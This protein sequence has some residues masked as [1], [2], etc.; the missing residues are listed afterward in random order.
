MANQQAEN[1]FRALIRNML[2][3]GQYP[4]HR[5]VRNALGTRNSGSQL[6]SGLTQEQTRWRAEEVERAGYDWIAS[7]AASRLVS[8]G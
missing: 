1:E 4:D 7:K 3:A 5:A 6:R 8:K 2:A